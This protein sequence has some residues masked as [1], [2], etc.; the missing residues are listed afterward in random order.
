M[1]HGEGKKLRE[2]FSGRH[3]LPRYVLHSWASRMTRF[4]TKEKLAHGVSSPEMRIPR[5]HEAGIL[6]R[7]TRQLGSI[8]PNSFPSNT[9]GSVRSAET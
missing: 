2:R 8:R 6:C 1:R 9:M 3:C 4:A 5:G 7:D